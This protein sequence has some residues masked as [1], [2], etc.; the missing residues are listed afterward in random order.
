MNSRNLT[1]FSCAIVGDTLSA[2]RLGAIVVKRR[3]S[4]EA[5]LGDGEKCLVL[6]NL[7]HSDNLVVS[8]K[9]DCLNSAGSTS[10]RTAV[11]F[12]KSDCP[13]VACSNEQVAFA[14]GELNPFKLV[15]FV[16][17]DCVDAALAV[18]IVFVKLGALDNAALCNHAEI[19]ALFR[20][21]VCLNHYA[22]L[23]VREK[24]QHVNNV[25]SL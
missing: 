17:D 6:V 22:D 10:N 21:V 14:V 16:K 13:A 1:E 8:A 20:K 7:N 5:G 12:L 19:F 2:S 11:G 23:F 25:E 9:G 3:P 4:T 24:R 18:G 15:T